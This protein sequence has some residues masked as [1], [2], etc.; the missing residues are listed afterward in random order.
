M[1][2]TGTLS[3]PD[4]P[5]GVRIVPLR[6][7]ADPEVRLAGRTTRLFGADQLSFFAFGDNGLLQRGGDAAIASKLHRESTLSLRHAAQVGGI[8]ERLGQ[9]HFGAMICEMPSRISVDMMMPR[10]DCQIA[11]DGS[12]KRLRALDF[13]L[14]D[15][16]EQDRMRLGERLAE[17]ALGTDLERLVATVDF[18]IGAVIQA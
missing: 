16:F 5:A 11:D 3:R 1:H 13:D 7:K 17:A 6:R 2:R 4:T 15:R 10:G 12:L 8:A 14:H 9:G 18:V